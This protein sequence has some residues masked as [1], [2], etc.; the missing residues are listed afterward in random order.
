MFGESS[1]Y[2]PRNLPG[3]NRVLCLLSYRLRCLVRTMELQSISRR[4]QRHVLA[5][6]LYPRNVWGEQTDLN[7]YQPRSQR[8]AFTLSYVHHCLEEAERI[9]L[10]QPEGL[11]GFQDR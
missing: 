8:G 1:E 9:E 4:W 10:S 2:R 6:E 3:K 11:H 7:R 5:I